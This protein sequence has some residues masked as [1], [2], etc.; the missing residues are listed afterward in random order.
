MAKFRLNTQEEPVEPL[1]ILIAP[2]PVSCLS[3]TDK[4]LQQYYSI[5]LN[6]LCCYFPKIKYRLLF[7][8]NCQGLSQIQS[9]D[10]WPFYKT[11]VQ[12]KEIS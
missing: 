4:E 8:N 3:F 5:L 1:A 7:L 2:S 9:K 12:L 6:L 11:P 10:I